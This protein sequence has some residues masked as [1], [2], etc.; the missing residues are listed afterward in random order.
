MSDSKYLPLVY[1][2][3]NSS[4]L[5]R[6]QGVL[7]AVRIG[8]IHCTFSVWRWL[9]HTTACQREN[10]RLENETTV[11]TKVILRSAL[12]IWQPPGGYSKSVERWL[13]DALPPWLQGRNWMTPRSLSESWGPMGNGGL[14]LGK[15]KSYSYWFLWHGLF[16]YCCFVFWVFFFVFFVWKKHTLCKKTKLYSRN[17]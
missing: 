13:E 17:K 7:S 11:E 1:R 6:S 12:V 8:G 14:I 10:W 5:W 4:E 15:M 16:C 9:F 2:K 3:N